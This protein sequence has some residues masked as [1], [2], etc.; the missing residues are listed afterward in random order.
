MAN[1]S[2]GRAHNKGTCLLKVL[3]YLVFGSVY[4]ARNSITDTQSDRRKEGRNPTINMYTV[5]YIIISVGYAI[6]GMASNADA[7]METI[8]IEP[9]PIGASIV[10]RFAKTSSRRILNSR[11]KFEVESKYFINI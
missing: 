3:N 8:R 5:Y 6:E 11:I 4:C 1:S 10:L 9:N 2:S 7:A